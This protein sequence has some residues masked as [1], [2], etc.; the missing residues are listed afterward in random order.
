LVR[1]LAHNQGQS[2]N[3]GRSP[4]EKFSTNG[5]AEPRLTSG[6]EAGT[7]ESSFRL[8]L[9]FNQYQA[10]QPEWMESSFRLVLVFNQ[11]QAA[12]PEW[13]ESSFRL[14]LVF[15]QHQASKPRRSALE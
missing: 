11:H 6:G 4:S 12:K 15:N 8:V 7:T 9:A 3:Q 14:V 13:M 5:E 10:A 2:P 1:P